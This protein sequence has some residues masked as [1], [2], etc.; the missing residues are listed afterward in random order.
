MP[1]DWDKTKAAALKILGKDGDVPDPPPA[2]IKSV[3]EVSK[4]ITGFNS[5]REDLEKT[6]L[7]MENANDGVKNVLKQ[8][9][10]S[11]AKSDLGLDPKNKDDAKKIAQARKILLDRMG[12]GMKRHDTNEKM[13]DELDKHVIQ[14]A[15]YKSPPI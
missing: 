10:A 3:D 13:L 5:A 15:K 7:T 14:L 2:L 6:I 12:D 11:L 4:A 1:F 9:S 8:F